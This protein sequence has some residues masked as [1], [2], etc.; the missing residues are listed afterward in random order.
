MSAFLSGEMKDTVQ[1]N[2]VGAYGTITLLSSSD[3]LRADFSTSS[4]GA[5]L[6]SEG[7]TEIVPQLGWECQH[8]D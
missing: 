5:I 2:P 6:F 3:V 7:K 1:M 4:P 8:V